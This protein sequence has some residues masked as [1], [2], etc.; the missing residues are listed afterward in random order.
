MPNQPD[1]VQIGEGCHPDLCKKWPA[2]KA[3]DYSSVCTQLK[4]IIQARNSL[5]HNEVTDPC[6]CYINAS[7]AVVAQHSVLD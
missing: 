1:V 7:Y 3:W 2:Y 4:D 6:L 5:N